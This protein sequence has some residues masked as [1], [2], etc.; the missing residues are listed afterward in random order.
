MRQFITQPTTDT[1][2]LK[3]VL[4]DSPF[5]ERVK[6]TKSLGLYF[7]FV[8]MITPNTTASTTVYGIAHLEYARRNYEHRYSSFSRP[9]DTLIIPKAELVRYPSVTPSHVV[10]YRQDEG[11]FGVGA[12][13]FHRNRFVEIQVKGVVGYATLRNWFP[14]YGIDVSVM[15]MKSKFELGISYKGIL[16]NEPP[17]YLSVSLSKV[18]YLS[19]IG[20]LLN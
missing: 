18:F 8:K 1:A 3:V 12:M 16:P 9:I 6:M 15:E 4:V 2:K 20:E 17:Y 14:W 7:Q 11:Y 19:K 13:V 10:K 5:V